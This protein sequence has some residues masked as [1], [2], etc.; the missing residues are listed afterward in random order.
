[1]SEKEKV[2]LFLK[3][4]HGY[5]CTADFVKLKID[6]HLIPNYIN[7]KII[8]KV[9][10]GIYI[11]NKLIEDPYYILQKRY[12]HAIFS[13]NTAFHIL[14]LTNRTPDR[15][16]ITVPHGKQ[17]KENYNIHYVSKKYF[18]IGIITTESPN[19]N[20]IRVYN[21]ERSICDMLKNEEDFDLELRNRILNYYFTS[22]DK[23]YDKLLQY[24]EVLGVYDKVIRIVEVMMKW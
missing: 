4:N 7:E 3:E 17:V 16:D 22:K 15:I 11:D 23:N 20:P 6:K 10:H 8:R 13:Y 2:L 14:N 12:S 21:A 9:S 19:G 24:A 5:I 18:D 1:M